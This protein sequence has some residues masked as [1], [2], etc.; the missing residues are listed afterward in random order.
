VDGD[1]DI[2]LVL[3]FRFGESG[4]A[5]GDVEAELIGETF[6]GQAIRGSDAIRTVGS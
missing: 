4:I 1:G 3:H 2:D 6:D 5:C